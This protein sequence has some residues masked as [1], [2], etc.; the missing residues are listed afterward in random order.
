MIPETIPG[1]IL[2]LLGLVLGVLWGLLFGR[3]WGSD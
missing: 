2:F 3:E 1:P